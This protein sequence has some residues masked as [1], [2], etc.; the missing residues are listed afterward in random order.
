MKST[1]ITL[2]AMV[3]I[4]TAIFG[5]AESTT[6]TCTMPSSVM[7][8]F[9]TETTPI[10]K[11]VAER[12][13]EVPG[14]PYSWMIFKH[15]ATFRGCTP[16]LE[17]IVVKT[18]TETGCG[19]TFVVGKTYLLTA[20]ISSSSTPPPSVAAWGLETYTAVSCNYNSEWDMVPYETQSALYDAPVTC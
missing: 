17:H 11:V 18:P 19:L 14:S 7:D 12:A 4:S 6:C 13:L 2:V 16:E 20:S 9:E 5:I 8:T 15:T 3:A 1:M 10:M